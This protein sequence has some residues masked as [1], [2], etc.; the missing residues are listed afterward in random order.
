LLAFS[1]EG[2]FHLLLDPL[3]GDRGLGEDEQQLV[4]RCRKARS[5]WLHAIQHLT[6]SAQFIGPCSWLKLV[7][8]YTCKP[9]RVPFIFTRVARKR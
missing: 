2:G 3:A 4:V 5:I 7:Y 8:T 9:H 6:G 1:C